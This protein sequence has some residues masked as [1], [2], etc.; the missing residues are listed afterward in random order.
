MSGHGK[1]SG[2]ALVQ[3]L[4]AVGLL[5]AALLALDTSGLSVKRGPVFGLGFLVIAGGV[6]GHVAAMLRLPRLTGFLVA[7]VLSG[8]QVFGVL[9][10]D[11][12]K[13]LSLINALALALIALQAGAE[14]T[15]N[16]LRRTW[17]SVLVSSGT[18]S[19]FVVA[20][21]AALFFALSS[22]MPF[23]S[24][25]E[26]GEVMTVGLVWGVLSL[27]RSPAVTLAI[28]GETR[29]KGP[30]SEH[31]LGVVVVLDVL[32]LPLFALAMAVAGSQLSGAPFELSAITHL[33]FELFASVCA[34][35]TF[36]LLIAVLLRFITG[37]RALVVV[38]LGFGVTALSTYLHYDT[39]VIFVVA[40]FIVTN[41]TRFG[42]DL[43]HTSEKVSAGVMIVFFATAGAKLDLDA[44]RTL[45]PL[46]VAFFVARAG[47]TVLA[48]RVGHR[49]AKDPE[50]VRKYGFTAFISQAGVTIG[51]ATLVA[52]RMPGIG[53]ALATL[54]IAV[55]SL[56]ELVGP[57]VFS[58]GLRRAGEVPDPEG[59]KP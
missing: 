37:A 28:L 18:Q 22:F 54:V 2:P 23:L 56:N 51:L 9:A 5:V 41:L 30:V 26:L 32:V 3:G 11:D 45:W 10:T 20:P 52:D 16:T 27:T 44:L 8:P 31:A 40:G 57:V 12:V 1:P 25:R 14:L 17:R 21:M 36:G 43:V 49:I 34:G 13:A 53:R 58:I 15:L 19:L 55:V 46:A 4:A 39:L 42:P 35:A 7:G 47:L 33:G 50:P 38:V 29:A 24:G 59:V 48:C 6:A